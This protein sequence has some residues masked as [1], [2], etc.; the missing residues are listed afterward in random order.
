[1]TVEAVYTAICG[2]LGGKDLLI[3][4]TGG[5]PLNQDP[6]ALKQLA[7]RLLSVGLSVQLETNGTIAS[8]ITE[9]CTYVTCSPKHG[10]NSVKINPGNVTCWKIVYPSSFRIDFFEDISRLHPKNVSF[11]LQPVEENGIHSQTSKENQKA[12]FLKVLELGYPWKLSL[13]T[14]KFIEVP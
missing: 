5:E 12:A 9:H 13:Q 3:V 2:H 4:L 8:D 1:M 14:H 10:I 6:Q 7:E 11:Y